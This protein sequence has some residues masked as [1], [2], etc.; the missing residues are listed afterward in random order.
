[1]T[2]MRRGCLNGKQLEDFDKA[3]RNEY[4]KGE[5]CLRRFDLDLVGFHDLLIY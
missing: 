5:N 2:V 1:M 3:S 4:L